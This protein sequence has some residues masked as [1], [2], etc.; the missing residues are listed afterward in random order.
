MKHL[1]QRIGPP[2][3]AMQSMQSHSSKALVAT[4]PTAPKKY[5]Y[6]DEVKELRPTVDDGKVCLR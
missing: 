4:A 6:D 2:A 3:S 1:S 5:Y